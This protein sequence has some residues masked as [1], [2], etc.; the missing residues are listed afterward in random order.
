M[1]QA[2]LWWGVSCETP[3]LVIRA[4]RLFCE[5][6]GVIALCPGC[7]RKLLH[8]NYL[9]QEWYLCILILLFLIIRETWSWIILRIWG[10]QL[11]WVQIKNKYIGIVRQNWVYSTRCAW[12]LG[13]WEAWCV[14]LV[15]S[16]AMRILEFFLDFI[17]GWRVIFEVKYDDGLVFSDRLIRKC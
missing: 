7:G 17:I 6:L 9:K 12:K 4:D 10:W 15:R 5:A 13:V 8:W 2:I 14:E 16:C 11:R 3:L 1:M